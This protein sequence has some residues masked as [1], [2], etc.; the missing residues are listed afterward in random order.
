MPEITRAAEQEAR[1]FITTTNIRQTIVT[2]HC[3]F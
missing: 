3:Q 2:Y 1:L